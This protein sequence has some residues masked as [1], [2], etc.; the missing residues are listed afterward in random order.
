MDERNLEQRYAIK[1]CVELGESTSLTY[2]KLRQSYG[3]HSLSRARVFWWHK[4]FWRAEKQWNLAQRGRRKRDKEKRV[5][6]LVRTDRR[7]TL[8]MMNSELHKFES[9][10]HPSDFN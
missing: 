9:F 3:E 2:K 5:G 4:S 10:Y 7:T 6:A 1:F 8:K